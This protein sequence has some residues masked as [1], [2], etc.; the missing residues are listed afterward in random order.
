MRF[1]DWIEERISFAILV[2]LAVW[3]ALSFLGWLGTCVS[4]LAAG[5]CL[6]L[7]PLN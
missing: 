3:G 4:F 1:W 2:T 7:N 5:V 6:G